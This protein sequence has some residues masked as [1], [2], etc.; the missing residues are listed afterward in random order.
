MTGAEIGAKLEETAQKQLQAVDTIYLLLDGLEQEGRAVTQGP[1]AAESFVER[2]R[3]YLGAF[4]F[5]TDG[6]EATG[7]AIEEL[8]E[9]IYSK[10]EIS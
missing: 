10:E 5:V 6:L 8:S 7:K 2:L 4:H 9:Q 3:M 1:A